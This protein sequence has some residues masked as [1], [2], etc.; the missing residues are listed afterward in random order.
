MDASSW[1]VRLLDLWPLLMLVASVHL[2]LQLMA[3]LGL[4]GLLELLPA[5]KR[6]LLS[7][8]C[9][10]CLASSRASCRLSMNF[11]RHASSCSTCCCTCSTGLGK[12]MSTPAAAAAAAAAW[13][14]GLMPSVL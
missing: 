4:S 10:G 7:L 9:C 2:L 14:S 3:V 6:L 8:R 1:P 12:D 13:G 5:G 11:S